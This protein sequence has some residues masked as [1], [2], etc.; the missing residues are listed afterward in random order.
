MFDKDVL[1]NVEGKKHWTPDPD[2]TP[3]A[4]EEMR[5]EVLDRITQN[6]DKIATQ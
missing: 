2:I 6:V 5:V 1:Y 3:E 4:L